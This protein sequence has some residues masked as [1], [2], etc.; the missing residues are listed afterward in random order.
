MRWDD[1]IAKI[2]ADH[3]GIF[4]YDPEV[5]PAVI[6]A[7]NVGK[8]RN[9][10]GLTQAQLA[11]AVGVAQPRIAEVER[12][13]A[14]PRLITLAKI[15]H[16]LGITLPELLE[17]NLYG[18]RS[19]SASASPAASAAGEEAEEAGPRKRRAG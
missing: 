10:L 18:N 5:N 15:A 3:P 1:L 14:N 4:D 17:D 13:D 2:E 7:F 12:G 11:E 16:A 8:A 9:Q 6:L 19:P